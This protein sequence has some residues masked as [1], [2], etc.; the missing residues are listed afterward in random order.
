MEQMSLIASPEEAAFNSI[1]PAFEKILLENWLDASYIT[2]KKNKYYY[3]ILFDDSLT[4][5]QIGGKKKLYFAVPTAAL[6][7]NS[8][9]RSLAH[10]KNAY[11]KIFLS[12]FDQIDQYQPLLVSILQTIIDGLPKEFDC[13]SR[14]VECSDAKKCTHPDVRESLKCGYRKVLLSGRVFYGKNRTVK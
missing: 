10:A 5:A 8:E 2:L 12:S 1:K 11:S 6:K 13:C 7:L 4:V 3:S 9:Y 14:Y